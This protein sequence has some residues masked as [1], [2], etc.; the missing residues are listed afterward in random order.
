M[1]SPVP[2]RPRRGR[3]DPNQMALPFGAP[4]PAPVP[5]ND[6]APPSEPQPAPPVPS[7]APQTMVVDRIAAA[8]SLSSAATPET[9]ADVFALIEAR[10]ERSGPN[11]E[12]KSALRTVARVLERPL[13][14]IPA[15]PRNLRRLLAQASP[16]V[17]GVTPDRWRRVRSLTLSALKSVG[18]NAMPGRH[19][20]GPSEAWRTL[21]GLDRKGSNQNLWRLLSHLSGLSIEPDAV[22]L[23]D[24]EGFRHALVN[25]SIHARAEQTYR[26]TV[27]AWNAA[28]ETV[29]GWPQVVV[30]LEPD[31]RLYS[32]DWS[33]FPQSFRDDVDAYLSDREDLDVLSKDYAR[34][35]RPATAKLRRRL[36]QQT[37]SALVISGFPIENLTSLA[38]LVEHANA[39]A[40]LGVLWERNDRKRKPQITNQ[41]NVLCVIAKQWVRVPDAQEKALRV[42]A[43]NLAVPQEG[44]AEKNRARLRQFD[45]AD[46]RAALLL[47][48][49]EVL[50]SVQK[51]KAPGEAEGRR[52]LFALAVEMQTMAPIR[53]DNFTGLEVDRHVVKVR[54]GKS[55]DWRLVIPK[56]ET[57]TQVPFEC[58]LPAPTVKLL[59]AYLATYRSLVSP[60]P[61]PFLF[62]NPD[63]QRRNTGAFGYAICEFVAKEGGLKMNLH[64]FRHLA[65]KLYLDVSPHDIETVRQLLTHKSSATTLKAYAELSAEHSVRRYDAVIADQR[66]QARG[67]SRK[68]RTTRG[69]RRPS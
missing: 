8:P 37:A 51:V 39:K 36:I 43:K 32:L 41:A 11:A 50:S 22:R 35:L 9:L 13:N 15:D 5:A 42:M 20:R 31:R 56:E 63:G 68:P 46:N 24:I 12:M 28:V 67:I 55:H 44:M 7:P 25:L 26:T 3:S 16:A 60:T 66:E 38:V 30:P 49:E 4:E 27:R 52:M 40:A 54:R 69:S 34:P 18:I 2:H 19:V 57:K 64:L 21:A 59:E 6:P 53:A 45:L 65:A 48:P 14:Q 10:P 58:R 17:G 1:A 62:P 33:A 23:A 61:T 47:L 29:P